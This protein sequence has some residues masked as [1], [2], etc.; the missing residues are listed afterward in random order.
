VSFKLFLTAG[1]KTIGT[2]YTDE[3]S[4][5]SLDVRRRF[6]PALASLLAVADERERLHI[7]HRLEE[8]LARVFRGFV[9]TPAL[10]HLATP[11]QP[12]R[13]RKQS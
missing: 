4:E 13:R 1:A 2:L 10:A 3:H 6:L 9:R 12:W 7:P 11:C 5:P 8:F